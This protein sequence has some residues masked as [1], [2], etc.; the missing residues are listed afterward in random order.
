MRS[1][2]IQ[3]GA[4]RANGLSVWQL[5]A[6]VGFEQLMSL[7]TGL[8]V[9]YGLGRAATAIFIPFLRDRAAELRQVPPFLIVTQNSD[10]NIIFAVIAVVFVSIVLGLSVFLLRKRLFSSLK[11]GEE[12]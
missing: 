5:I 6:V 10:I 12:G 8:G 9:G 11:L 3:F 1:R 4:L 2:L 7:G